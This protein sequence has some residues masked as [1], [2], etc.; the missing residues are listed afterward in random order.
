MPDRDVPPIYRG[1]HLAE[2][3]AQLGIEPGPAAVD[4]RV[5]A[6][7]IQAVLCGTDRIT[8]DLALRLGRYFDRSATLGMSL[9]SNSVR[10]EWG[11]PAESN[12]RFSQTGTLWRDNRA[13][14]AGPPSRVRP[15]SRRRRGDS[16]ASPMRRTFHAT[17]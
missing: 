6:S 9:Q 11:R 15:P 10:R 7:R 3:L 8:A 1:H 12:P 16:P 2:F 5:P 13:A 17:P 14:P 4:L